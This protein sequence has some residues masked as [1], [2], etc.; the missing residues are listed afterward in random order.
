MINPCIVAD[1]PVNVAAGQPLVLRYRLVLFDGQL[2]AA[3][4]KSL[5]AEWR[6][7]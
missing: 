4:V 7:S 1:G 3:L 5:S 6:R 2:P